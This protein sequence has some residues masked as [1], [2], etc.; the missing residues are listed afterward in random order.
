M[1]ITSS[2]ASAVARPAPPGNQATRGAPL[3]RWGRLE[4][5]SCRACGAACHGAL[6]RVA[7]T[8]A[9]TSLAEIGRMLERAKADRS[10][11]AL[12]ADRIA[13]RFVVGVLVAAS[14]AAL[15][16]YF[17]DAG[18]AFEVAL[19]TL[20]VT[21]PCALALATPAALAAASSMTVILSRATAARK[22]CRSTCAGSSISPACRTPTG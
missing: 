15:L 19:A 11:I 7:Q 3:K 5:N 8:G 10:P 1:V 9:G 13:S 2:L 22:A 17:I 14:F 20:V 12:L 6:L 18:R 4:A 16:W 21:C